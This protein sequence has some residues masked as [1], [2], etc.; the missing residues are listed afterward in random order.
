[1]NPRNG[2]AM[3]SLNYILCP[4]CDIRKGDGF[5][6]MDLSRLRPETITQ[7][8]IAAKMKVSLLA[9]ALEILKVQSRG[10]QILNSKFRESGSGIPWLLIT[11]LAIHNYYHFWKKQL[12]QS[13]FLPSLLFPT[14]YNQYKEAGYRSIKAKSGKL[15]CEDNSRSAQGG[16][17]WVCLQE[18]KKRDWCSF[19]TL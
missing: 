19:R 11:V 6:L 18:K 13:T 4:I 3:L 7:E 12:A 1:M 15:L 10:T 17:E 8:R 14:F 2:E 5:V 16:L 9:Q